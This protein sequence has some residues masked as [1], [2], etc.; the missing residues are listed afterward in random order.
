[1]TD[2]FDRSFV[3]VVGK[4]GR[5]LARFVDADYRRRMPAEDILSA[6]RDADRPA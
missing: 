4:G 2:L 6:L 3:F 5:V 1:M